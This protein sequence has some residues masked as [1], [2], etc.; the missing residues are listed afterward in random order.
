MIDHSIIRGCLQ[1][2]K[3]SEYLLY[4][5][6]FSLLMKVCY[7]YT[8]NKDDAMDFVNRGFLKI[9][10]NLDKYDFQ[11]PYEAWI[12][13]IMVNVII[14]EFRKNKS[15]KEHVYM[16]EHQDLATFQSNTYSINDGEQN[17]LA[18]EI[19]NLVQQ[20]PAMA[21]EVLN[22]NVFDGYS[23]KEIGE[24]MG[25][26]EAASKWHLFNARNILK[27]KISKLNNSSVRKKKVKHEAA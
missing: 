8:S 22:L 14:D 19:M 7:R 26:S 20:L 12:R 11:H 13:R 23:H 21:R 6:S 18:S 24:M 4:K 2:D 1:K 3:K 9:L 15:Y 17:L 5:Q 16:A 10:N 25:I 27:E